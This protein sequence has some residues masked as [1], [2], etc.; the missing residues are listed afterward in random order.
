MPIEEFLNEEGKDCYAMK[1]I[2]RVREKR[3]RE[4]EERKA[5][6]WKEQE[7]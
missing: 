4:E 5:V 6:I 3:K 2:N 7:R 1:R